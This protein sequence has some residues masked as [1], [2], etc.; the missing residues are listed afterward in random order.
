VVT[1]P[2]TDNSVGVDIIGEQSNVQ[3]FN[4]ISNPVQLGDFVIGRLGLSN[5]GEPKVVGA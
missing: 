1:G 3:A 4:A 2:A 5:V